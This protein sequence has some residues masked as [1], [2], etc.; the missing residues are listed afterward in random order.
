MEIAE[1]KAALDE[2]DGAIRATLEELQSENAELKSRIEWLEA[3]RER[4]G[5]GALETEDK[6]GNRKYRGALE[7]YFRKGDP[8]KLLE[9]KAGEMAIGSTAQGSYMHVAQLSADIIAAIGTDSNLAKNVAQITTDSNEYRVIHTIVGAGAS[10]AAEL[11]SRSATA[12]PTQARVDTT[13]YDMY[14]VV[15]VSNEL[16]DSAQFDVAGY[17]QQEALRQFI[18]TIESEIV[19]GSGSTAGLGINTQATSTLGEDTSPLRAFSL[20]QY[21][22]S[23]SSPITKLAY[24]DIVDLVAALPPRYLPNAKFYASNSA[25][26]KLRKLK[27][28]Q[29]LPIWRDEIGVT[30]AVQ[31]LLGYPVVLC[32]ALPAI[33]ASSK[34]LWFG[35]LQRAYGW[36]THS[37]GLRIIRDDI[38][39]L[40]QTRFYLSLQ[41]GG[42]PFDTRGIKV[43]RCG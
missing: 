14:A 37:R 9:L 2:R 30:G 33:A 12:A 40:G 15:P 19:A 17:V 29:S 42:K 11:G 36:V 35:D 39:T 23:T 34:S 26:Q 6:A 5:R 24:D 22:S 25:V 4:F 1:V 21:V 41:N 43:Y 16:L 13:L 7:H 8:G 38:S 20:V 28:G 31:T 32:S 3:A 10:R 18:A 27:D